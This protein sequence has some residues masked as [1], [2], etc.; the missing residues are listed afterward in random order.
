MEFVSF[1][2]NMLGNDTF[3][4]KFI[5]T[6]CIVAGSIFEPTRAGKIV[7][8]L[9]ATVK[10]MT[11]LMRQQ[12]I[13]DGH[14]PDR[15]AQTIK[16]KLNG[17]SEKMTG[18]MKKVEEMKLNVGVRKNITLTA[19]AEGATILINGIAVPTGNATVA[20]DQW[21]LF[22]GH[23]FTPV[24]VEAKAP[25]GYTFVGWKKGDDIIDTQ[26][27]INVPT[28]SRMTLTA[29]FSEIPDSSLLTPV[30]INEVNAANDIYVSEYFKRSDWVELYNTT[31]EPIDVA[32]MYLSDNPDKP[33][34]YQIEAPI[35]TP[36]EL[37]PDAIT[38]EMAGDQWAMTHGRQQGTVIPP[39]GYLIVWCDQREPL[40]QLHASFKLA[41]EGDEL[42]LTAADESWTDRLTYGPM[43]GNETAGRYPDGADEVFTMNVPTIAKT[44]ITSSYVKPSVTMLK[45]DVNRDGAVDVADVSAVISFMAGSTDVLFEYADVNEDG[46]VD[47]ADIS[48]IITIMAE[49]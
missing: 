6:F 44:N 49:K 20:N 42:L 40:T 33:K 38:A 27:E 8:E 3:R 21:T 25:H 9:L 30:R 47:V 17:R 32:G 34:K 24:K 23:L 11:Q 1:F 13:Y 31:D 35:F 45:G 10:P 15:S 29:V 36:E 5:D 22:S 43:K 2:Y 26:P 14:D 18:Y 4:R 28:G 7:D 46:A 41:A 37:A 19:N 39:H 48:A 12:G 16:N